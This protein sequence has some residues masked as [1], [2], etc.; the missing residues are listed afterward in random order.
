MTNTLGH[1][2]LTSTRIPILLSEYQ[3]LNEYSSNTSI[4]FSPTFYRCAM[5]PILVEN[6]NFLCTC[7]LLK[8]TQLCTYKTGS[9]HLN[10]ITWS[11]PFQV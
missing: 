9:S 2:I 10:H 7:V 4:C 6:F 8:A 11:D 5:V 1:M 3:I